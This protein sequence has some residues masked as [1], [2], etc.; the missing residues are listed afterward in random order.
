MTPLT[1]DPY[2]TVCSLVIILQHALSE[3]SDSQQMELL[4][5]KS[6]ICTAETHVQKHFSL[7]TFLINTIHKYDNNI[8]EWDSGVVVSTISS[9]QAGPGFNSSPGP[10]VWILHAQCLSGFSAGVASSHSRRVNQ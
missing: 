6:V 10:S 5:G 3:S 8:W 9:Q 4:T 2:R 7:G 1:S